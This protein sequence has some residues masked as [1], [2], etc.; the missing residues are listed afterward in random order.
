MPVMWRRH[1]FLPTIAPRMLQA[2]IG[3]LFGAIVFFL[4]F[5]ASL[6]DPT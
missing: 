6:L 5:D 2:A 3:P 1:L 4:M